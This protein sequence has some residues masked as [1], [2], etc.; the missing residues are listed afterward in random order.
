MRLIEYSQKR[1]VYYELVDAAATVASSLSKADGE[2]HAAHFYALYFG[3]AHVAVI[4]STVYDAKK[5]FSHAL[6]RALAAGAWPTDDLDMPALELSKACQKVLRAQ[7]VIEDPARLTPE[8][9]A[10]DASR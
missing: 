1:D 5:Q 2:K 6:Q 7:N 3:K 4:D 9:A 8:Q 10:S